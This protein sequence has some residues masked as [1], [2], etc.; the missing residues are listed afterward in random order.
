VIGAGKEVGDEPGAEAG[1]VFLAIEGVW[2]RREVNWRC[3]V[4]WLW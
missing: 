2:L 4:G 3:R 1:C